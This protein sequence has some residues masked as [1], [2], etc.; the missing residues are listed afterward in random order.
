MRANNNIIQHFCQAVERWP[1]K[2]AIIS[3]DTTITYAELNLL[4][5]QAASYFIAKGIKKDSRVL[6]F[7]PMGIDLYKIVLA[8]FK[9]GATAVFL[10]EWVN[11][12]RMELCCEVAQC[13]AFIGI[14]KA[15]VLSIFSTELRKIPIKLGTQIPA[16]KP[17]QTI[18]GEVN[19]TDIALITF[20]TGTTGK[21]KAAKRTHEFLQEQFN[22]LTDKMQPQADD[23]VLTMLPI[24]LLVNLG[25]GCTSVICNFNAK[26]PEKMHADEIISLIQRTKVSRIIGSPFFVKQLAKFV[27][28][29]K[30][31]LKH[32]TH[33]FAGGA[34]VFPNE[35]EIYS[36]AFNYSKIEIVYGSTEAEPISAITAQDLSNARNTSF[37]EG[38]NVGKPYWNINVKIIRL[39]DGPVVCDDD[40]A[41]AHISLENNSI[42]EI[43]VSG[44]HVLREYY[45]ND[46]ALKRNKIIYG[47]T[48]WH[49][50]GDSGYINENG[51]LFLTGR[52]NTLIH[53]NGKIIAP[54]IFE[55]YLQSLNE[56]EIG[57]IVSFNQ[58]I[59]AVVE[60]NSG[61]K[62]QFVVSQILEQYPVIQAVKI[63]KKI[64]RDPRHNSKIDYERLKQL[65]HD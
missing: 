21:P 34:P 54:F 16:S 14:F 46:E 11:K 64:P 27:T 65:L 13:N 1:D 26:Q 29:H 44:P 63:L 59:I 33:V 58:Q 56:V 22:A 8:L 25:I 4:V 49:R 55:N 38:L 31:E 35:S 6:I 52:C 9:I 3:E 2:P 47:N 20:T 5:D 57:T 28:T 45:N 18:I 43:I 42:G 51:E 30:I 7:V 53:I 40:E 32:V 60:L 39:I 12:S 36:N 10:D 15:R 50:T 48:C 61:K 62:N 23:V 41:L 17:A 24:V 37:N 19:L